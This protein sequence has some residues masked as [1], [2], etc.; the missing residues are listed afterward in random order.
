MLDFN[1]QPNDSER[2]LACLDAALQQQ[3]AQETPR[4]YLGASRLGLPCERQLQFEYAGAP[5]DAGRGFS[6]QL[7]RVFDVGHALEELAIRWLRA[8][9]F[10]LITHKADG[11]QI[12]FASAG[13]RLRGHIDGLITQLPES[14]GEYLSL[15][16]L[17]ECKSMHDASWKD[18]V[19]RGVSV[20]KPIYAAQIAIYQAYLEAAIPGVSQNPALFTAINKDTQAIYFE[21][22]PFNADLA[23]RMSDR[24]VRV[25]EATERHALLPRMS[26]TPTHFVCKACAYAERCW[27]LPA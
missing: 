27:S 22:V 1:H 17:W 9:G 20:S 12:G 13:G 15:P 4:D 14:L 5:V 10:M 6:G 24:A 7:L 18:T 19:K 3:R 16:M 23:Q 21:L 2:L 25:L 11:G 8:A 26:T